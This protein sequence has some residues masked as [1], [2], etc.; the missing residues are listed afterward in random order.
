MDQATSYGTRKR[1]IDAVESAK[2]LLQ[3]GLLV[4]SHDPRG[5]HQRM[6]VK[7]LT[8]FLRQQGVEDVKGR[9]KVN[10]INKAMERCPEAVAD[11]A[12]GLCL[13]RLAPQYVVAAVWAHEHIDHSVP[14]FQAW[15]GFAFENWTPVSKDRFEQITPSPHRGLM[16]EGM[17]GPNSLPTKKNVSGLGSPN[18]HIC[19]ASRRN[20]DAKHL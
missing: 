7:E 10:L 9:R 11:K 15:L 8:E 3:S 16:A 13:A 1:G 12:K 17:F 18:F 6:T 4:Q 14:F 19:F 2:L 20:F 5:G